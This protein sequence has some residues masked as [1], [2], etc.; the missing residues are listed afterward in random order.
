MPRLLPS[1]KRN[2]DVARLCFSLI[3]DRRYYR[4]NRREGKIEGVRSEINNEIRNDGQ[5][6]NLYD[7]GSGKGSSL[8]DEAADS[9]R[10]LVIVE[11]AK[12]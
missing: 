1:F 12:R 6:V 5:A 4:A 2:D 9:S 3:P 8:F 11:R 7:K 10:K